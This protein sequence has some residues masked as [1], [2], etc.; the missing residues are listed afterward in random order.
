MISKLALAKQSSDL[1]SS[2]LTQAIALELM[3]SGFDRS[4][5]LSIN[6]LYRERRDVLCREAA[7][8]IG[9]WFQW[10][11]PAGGMFV[12]MRAKDPRID[13]DELYRFA[14]EEKVAFVPGSVF[15]PE[16]KDRSAMRVNF[17]RSA[18]EVIAEGIVRLERAIKRYLHR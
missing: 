10:E 2:L 5:S 9:E 17:T 4:H 3:E 12:W 11:V 18:P 14:L 13:T 1:S 6:D 15:D 8:R 7:A 16:G